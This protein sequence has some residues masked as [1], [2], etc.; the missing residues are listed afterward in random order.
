VS[1]AVICW[2]TFARNLAPGWEWVQAGFDPIITGAIG[3]AV[4]MVTA[5]LLGWL[6]QRKP[7]AVIS[8]AE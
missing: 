4:L 6:S 1:I 2:G 5:M 8:D 7:A 3:T